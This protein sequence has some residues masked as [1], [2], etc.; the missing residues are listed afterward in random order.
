MN[1]A[2]SASLSTPASSSIF[3]DS[4]DIFPSNGPSSGTSWLHPAKHEHE[5]YVGHFRCVALAAVQNVFF[6]LRN[7]SAS[8][9]EISGYITDLYS[10]WKVASAHG[11]KFDRHE[12][13]PYCT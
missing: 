5:I 9:I 4:D 3:L 11:A 12:Q 7:A 13:L 2:S 10:E 8:I 1:V 6:L